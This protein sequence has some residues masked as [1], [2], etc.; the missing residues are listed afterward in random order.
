[1]TPEQTFIEEKTVK[2]LDGHPSGIYVDVGIGNT[3]F[4]N[5]TSQEVAWL[6][7]T[8]QQALTKGA[9]IERER[10]LAALP[11][12]PYEFNNSEEEAIAATACR[13]YIGQIRTLITTPNNQIDV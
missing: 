9:E 1:M 5:V 6:R 13:K 12:N 10:I 7:T 2:F 8:L 11:A 3:T 4:L